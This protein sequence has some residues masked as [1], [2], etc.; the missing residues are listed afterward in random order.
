MTI[1]E[2]PSYRTPDGKV[3]STK[4]EAILHT[5]RESYRAQAEIYAAKR[6]IEGA[7]NKTRAVNTIIDYCAF[8]ELQES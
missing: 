6:G 2:V 4:E 8:E 7:A 1:E 3:F 5:K